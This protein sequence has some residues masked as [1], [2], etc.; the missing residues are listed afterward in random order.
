MEKDF[1]FQSK[2]S[3]L[4]RLPKAVALADDVVGNAGVIDVLVMSDSEDIAL[5]P[6][7]AVIHQRPADLS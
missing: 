5:D 2:A 1:A 4:V 7:R 3:Q 6:Q